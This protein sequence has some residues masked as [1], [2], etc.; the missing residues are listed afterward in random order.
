MAG[1]LRRGGANGGI[2]G[3]GPRATAEVGP[4]A[5]AARDAGGDRAITKAAP[6]REAGCGAKNGDWVRI[7]WPDWFRRCGRQLRGLDYGGGRPSP[8][9]AHLL[10]PHLTA[11]DLRPPDDSFLTAEYF[12]LVDFSFDLACRR[13]ECDVEQSAKKDIGSLTRS[14]EM[15]DVVE[16]EFHVGD[17]IAG[18]VVRECQRATEAIRV[19]RRQADDRDIVGRLVDG[20]VET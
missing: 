13:I 3:G 14:D 20:E 8:A 12:I 9:P 11:Q 4:C 10:R 1:E 19:A 7:A 5:D 15:V 6:G 2:P 17:L 18:A 16:R